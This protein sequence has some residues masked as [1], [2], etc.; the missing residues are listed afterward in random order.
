MA[1]IV[2]KRAGRRSLVF[3]LFAV[4]LVAWGSIIGRLAIV[5]NLAPWYAGLVKPSF[6]PPNFIF[7][8]VWTALCLLMA[9]ALWRILRLP[10]QTPGR[11]VAVAVFLAQLALVARRGGYA[12]RS[13]SNLIMTSGSRSMANSNAR[14]GAS[15]VLRRCSQSR[16]VVMGKWKASANCACVIPRRC[17]SDLT[18]DTRRILASCSAVRG[19]ASGSA[20]AAA[21]SS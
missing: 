4:G 10:A 20:S 8:P 1:A 7:G 18:R 6:N 14:A 11:G 9:F 3:G 12:A 21:M 2:E 19:C 16:N 5:P 13:A 17:R 15:G